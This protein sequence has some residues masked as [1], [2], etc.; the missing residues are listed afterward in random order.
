MRNQ[1]PI[2]NG[3]NQN[4]NEILALYAEAASFKPDTLPV[5]GPPV[6]TMGLMAM[7]T[8]PVPAGDAA[9][10]AARDAAGAEG[11]AAGGAT[12]SGR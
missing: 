2:C 9:G 6:P 4:E 7:A 10:D 8:A 5:I 11:D 3:W 12:P 1:H